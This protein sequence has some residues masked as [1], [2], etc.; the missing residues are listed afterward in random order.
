MCSL[1]LQQKQDT[2]AIYK[3]SGVVSVRVGGRGMA[4]GG[5]RYGG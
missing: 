2:K 1:D 5:R 4:G 3:D